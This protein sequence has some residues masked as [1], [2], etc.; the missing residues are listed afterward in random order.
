MFQITSIVLA[1]KNKWANTFVNFEY[2]HQ[3]N[4]LLRYLGAGNL[5]KGPN[6][7]EKL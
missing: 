3:L 6:N 5:F 4:S 1:K 2:L 7:V